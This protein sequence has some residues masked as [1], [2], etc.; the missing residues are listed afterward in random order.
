MDILEKSLALEGYKN[1]WTNSIPSSDLKPITLTDGPHGLRLVAKEEKGGFE[2]G[3]ALPSTCFPTASA[4]ACTFNKE[5]AYLEGKTIAKECLYYNVACILGPGINLK[6]NPLCGRNFE[7]FSEDPLLSGTMAGYF[8]KGVE[9][10]GVSACLKHFICNNTED[11]RFVSDSV[12][13]PRA[14]NEIYLKNFKIAMDIK[15]PSTIM[16]SYNSING[17]PACQ[18]SYLLKDILRDKFKFDGVIMTDWGGMHDR[19]KSLYATCDLEMPGMVNAH[20]K[21]II[22]AY[23]ADY[24]F[25][26]VVD[27]SFNRVEKLIRKGNALKTIKDIDFE[28]NALNSLKIALESAVLLKNNKH[29]LPLKKDKKYLIIGS[30][31][32]DMRYQGAGSSLINAYKL[33]TPYDAFKNNNVNF[34]YEIGFDPYNKKANKKLLKKALDK[35]KKYDDIIL[36]LG[37]DEFTEMEGFDRKDNYLPQEQLDLVNALIPLKKKITIVLSNGSSI[38]LPFISNV[39]SILEMYLG[40]QMQ[41]EACYRLLFGLDNPSGKLAETWPKKLDNVPFINEYGKNREEYYKESIFIGY[42]YYLSHPEKILFPFGFGLSYTKFKYSQIE[43]E[44]KKDLIKVRYKIKNIGPMKGKETSFVFISKDDSLTYR[45]VREL[46]GF[47]KIELDVNEQKEVEINI[48]IEELK[49]Y[50]TNLARFVLE[51]GRY[52]I[53]VGSS[54]TQIELNTAIS[55]KG[56]KI[57]NPL[58]LEKYKKVDLDSITLD[59]FKLLYNSEF[60]I[61]VDL[62]KNLDEK[63]IKE[64]SSHFGKLVRRIANRVGKHKIRKANHIRDKK[65]R[66]E[67]VKN[68][69]FIYRSIDNTPMYLG[70]NNSSGVI[71]KTLANGLSLM[72][73]GHFFKGLKI[74]LKREKKIPRIDKNKK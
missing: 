33:V 30:F 6:R 24:S 42:R 73:N 17:I 18:N 35:A 62:E 3:N 2:V 59:D 46:K 26:S 66:R 72:C 12:V 34:E 10:N 23:N 37:L 61:P 13:D 20:R 5:L 27:S 36:F 57:T 11:L 28:E 25:K 54:S 60:P 74:I 48:P 39:D 53:E 69:Y 50:E 16:S 58:V 70:C 56:E 41:G 22:E 52:E 44:V 45:P 55:L 67:E 65:K 71:T 49:Y 21:E 1:W 19:I 68:A 47:E 14:L 38:D 4:L 63:M 7:Y 51:D 64:Y 15:M 40:G 9:E 29:N 31:F 8:I 43:C 32:K